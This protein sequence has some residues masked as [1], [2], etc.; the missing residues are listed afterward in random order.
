MSITTAFYTGM[1][2]I[3]KHAPTSLSPRLLVSSE[4]ATSHGGPALDSKTSKDATG[5]VARNVFAMQ[6][7]SPTKRSLHTSVSSASYL[8]S[9]RP[10]LSLLQLLSVRPRSR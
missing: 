7:T 9:T 1:A 5:I 10:R 3:S 6:I 8:S 2:R 4:L